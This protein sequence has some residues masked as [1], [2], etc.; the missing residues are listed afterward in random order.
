MNNHI[1]MEQSR[2]ETRAEWLAPSRGGLPTLQPGDCSTRRAM[3]YLGAHPEVTQLHL[4][5]RVHQHVGRLH[6][7]Q[8]KP[9]VSW[10]ILEAYGDRCDSNTSVGV[11]MIGVMEFN[12]G[13]FKG[14]L[15]LQPLVRSCHQHRWR[16]TCPPSPAIRATEAAGDTSWGGATRALQDGIWNSKQSWQMRLKKYAEIQ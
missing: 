1:Q 5:S 12:R 9:E 16:C 15:R 14:M 6:V 2:P 3:D 8:T 11:T 10:V 7:C 13:Y 4:P